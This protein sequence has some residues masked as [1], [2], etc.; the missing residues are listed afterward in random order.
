MSE[1]L[2][3]DREEAAAYAGYSPNVFD[4]M[5]DA[6]EMPKPRRSAVSKRLIWSRVE[7]DQA[8]HRLPTGE[9]VAS[10]YE[11]VEL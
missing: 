5:V 11:G 6:G 1:R 7:I 10:E 8:V 2:G 3:L 4:K 9:E